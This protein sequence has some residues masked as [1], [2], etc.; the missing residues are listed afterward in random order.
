VTQSADLS[1]QEQGG[2]LVAS[3]HPLPTV[4][5]VVF[6]VVLSVAGFLLVRNWE[7]VRVEQ[8]FEGRARRDGEAL[9]V[10]LERYKETL[11]TL[12]V[13]FTASDEVTY[14]EFC[15]AAMDL[16]ERHRGIHRLAWIPRVAQADR[17]RLEAQARET[18]LPNYRIFEG[19]PADG[20]T[21]APLAAR[22][23]E[24]RGEYLPILYVDPVAE[25]E[26][27]FG[28]DELTGPHQRAIMRARDTG[29]P[30]A[31][32]RMPLSAA[33]GD[34]FGWLIFL[35]IYGP[36]PVPKTVAERRERFRGHLAGAFHFDGLV[37]TSM[38]TEQG[39]EVE[40]LLVDQT[41]GGSDPFLIY[42]A[43]GRRRSAP[44][45]DE[46]EFRAGMHRVVP[47]P[48]AGRDWCAY[49]RPAPAW[50]AAR[51]TYYSP[52]FL[53]GGL[54]LTGL[55]ASVTGLLA[56]VLRG[57]QHRATQ[58]EKLVGQRTA[59]LAATEDALRDDLRQRAKVE[60]ALRAGEERYRALIANSTE[61]IWRFEFDLP[62]RLDRPEDEQIDH[63]HRLGYL[64]ECNDAYARMY[65]YASA[66]E[67]TGTRLS[68]LL[69]ISDPANV[70]HLR[71]H[72]RGK[73]RMEDSESHELD[74]HGQSRIFLNNII[75]I[76]EDGCLVRTWG[77]QRDITDLRRAEEEKRDQQ[78][79]LR[80][81]LAA[82]DLGTWEWDLRGSRIVWSD[83]T[84]RIFG[85][86]PG[87]FDGRL[88]T[89][90]SFLHPDD[91]ATVE[92]A[93]DHAVRTASELMGECRIIRRDGSVRWLSV[94]GDALSDGSGK[95]VRVLG[96][97]MDI[98]QQHEAASE[99]ALI[100]KKLQE[101]QKLESLG[102]LAG[103][104]AHDFNNLLTGV[105]GNANLARMDLPPDSPAQPSLEAIENVAQR[106]AELCKQML[107][108]SGKGRFVV[109]RLNLSRVVEDTA[110]LIHTSVRKNAVL[111]FALAP[112]LPPISGDITQISQIVMNL[113]I[114]ASDAIGDQSGV[115]CIRT[116]LIH[117][118]RAYLAGTY[119]SP[120]L[121]EGNYVFLE[122]S[123]N[124]S[125]MSSETRA[126]IFDPFFTTKFT[127]RGLGLAAV[128]G[129]VRGH[130]GALNVDSEPG[131]GS[132]FQLLLPPA[133]GSAQHLTRPATSPNEWRSSGTVLVVDDEEAVRK[134]SARMLESW[135]FEAAL[136]A[137]GREALAR[138][139][140]APDGFAAILLDLTMP[141]MDGFQT[142][143]E[144]RRIRSD[145]RVLL[146][147]GFNEQ[148][149]L[150]RFAG[151]G[152]PGFLQ[153]PFRREAL[154]A[155]LR[156]MFEAPAEV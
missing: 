135:G 30:A 5:A 153:K 70:E 141:E 144:L 73:F 127:G 128:L 93:V 147:S 32:R 64:A 1:E 130:K 86:E 111:K 87:V 108:Y 21:P 40:V 48:V 36:G 49:F 112:D 28:R 60:R 142:F 41:P 154:Q 150:T 38:G 71:K 152:V 17:T 118:D 63:L 52:A 90:R 78:T 98:T 68:D 31:T 34:D 65:G 122:V 54:L 107:A 129:I 3:L 101:T 91:E 85:L 35:P 69:P 10:T 102:I 146:M 149:A 84:E 145:V 114:N 76:I 72:V 81:A 82:A 43:D 23:A 45:P 110:E 11:Y 37:T 74:R 83:V 8:E 55:L 24:E 66:E 125:G 29:E 44:P 26:A 75:G 123:D 2:G 99:R 9:A 57:A 136:A 156:A 126:R 119:L 100:E 140:A 53:A 79:H 155:R 92:A 134:V 25:N 56:S 133:E 143:T 42:S 105:L 7:Q 120:N 62:V 113:V 4:L 109:Q 14:P 151:K 131:K 15:S 124:G 16:R 47:L 104:I 132:I 89:C 67:I 19:T 77:T 6:G 46:A 96:A 22:P 88:E 115:I 58:V 27:L 103:G 50:L 137:N 18:I 139:Q 39:G 97:V 13:L 51:A 59:E 121:P 94:R 138:F 95:V 20:S 148:D 12:R 116:G 117:A 80:L 106:A 61:G 33:A